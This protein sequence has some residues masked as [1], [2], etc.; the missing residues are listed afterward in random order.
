[1][2]GYMVDIATS[3]MLIGPD[4]AQN[5]EIYDICSSH[6]GYGPPLPLP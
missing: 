2:A 5:K 4:L 1:M 6:S 3:D